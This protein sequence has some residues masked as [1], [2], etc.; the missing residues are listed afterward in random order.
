MACRTAIHLWTVALGLACL[1]MVGCGSGDGDTPP[2]SDEE[3]LKPSTRLWPDVP[4]PPA[5]RQ[6]VKGSLKPPAEESEKGEGGKAEDAG[7]SSGGAGADEAPA[8]E[9]ADSDAG[10][11]ES[12]DTDAWDTTSGGA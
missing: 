8:A 6:N 2:P 4:P 9:E 5:P 1:W 10:T 11:G 3:R 7:E 12:S